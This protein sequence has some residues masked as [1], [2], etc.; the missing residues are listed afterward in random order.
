MASN[1]IVM[2]WNLENLFP[3]EDTD[4]SAADTYTA[5]LTY[6]A[7]LIAGTGGVALQEIRSLRADLQTALGEPGRP[8]CPP[9]R[10]AA[11]SAS[12]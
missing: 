6:L 3:P 8:S 10:T 9:T 12:P 1:L 11:A 5:K 4:T 2:T 7:G